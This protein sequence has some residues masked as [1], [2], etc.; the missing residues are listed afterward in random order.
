MKMLIQSTTHIGRIRK[1]QAS[2]IEQVC[3][4]LNWTHD[5]YCDHQYKEYEAF[6]ARMFDGYP[7]M[8]QQVRYSS[9]FRGFWNNE[10]AIRN[11][12]DFLPFA[13]E[14]QMDEAFIMEEYL[15]IHSHYRLMNDDDFLSKYN[16][17]LKLI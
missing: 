16:S 13:K 7:V 11:E 12:I 2:Q 9:A 15:Y 6:I 17:A 1:E 10:W 3:D 5:E 8:M 14:C 4:L